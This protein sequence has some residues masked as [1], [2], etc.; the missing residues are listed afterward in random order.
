MSALRLALA[1]GR[2]QPNAVPLSS[3]INSCPLTGR[4]SPAPVDLFLP[5]PFYSARI[6]SAP[7]FALAT[8]IQTIQQ[9]RVPHRT[10]PNR[11]Q[12]LTAQH[13]PA[14][15]IRP[16]QRITT[17]PAGRLMHQATQQIM[18]RNSVP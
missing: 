9:A 3:G 4:T 8:P 1:N 6:A 13:T 18:H 14:T 5:R 2:R 15:T 12:Q 10:L 11:L 17:T 7:L 16:T